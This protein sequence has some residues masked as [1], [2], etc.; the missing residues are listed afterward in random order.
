LL[1]TPHPSLLM[2]FTMRLEVFH[3][4]LMIG[5]DAGACG[6]YIRRFF[7]KTPLVRYDTLNILENEIFPATEAEFWRRIA[8]GVVEN[9]KTVKDLLGELR[10]A[11]TKNFD[12]LLALPQGFQSKIFHTIAHLLDGFIGIDSG[13]YNL[14][15]DSHWV[16]DQLQLEMKEN[17]G[18]YWLFRL[19]AVLV[20]KERLRGKSLRTFETED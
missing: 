1:L 11:G 12:D 4:V 18:D 10:E 6:D 5:P 7:E 14:V 20:V 15:E 2:N 8:D 13:F 16:S 19:E 3:T 9:R 17:P